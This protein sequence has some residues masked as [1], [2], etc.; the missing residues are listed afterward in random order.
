MA[1]FLELKFVT[2][3]GNKK[4]MTINVDKISVCYRSMN[5]VNHSEICLSENGA[6]YTVDID[7]QILIG[8]LGAMQ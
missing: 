4:L 8:K 5:V 2:T 7:Y 3:D 6:K 1:K